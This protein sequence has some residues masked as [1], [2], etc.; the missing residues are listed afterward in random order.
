MRA[1][2]VVLFAVTGIFASA[3]AQTL[4]SVFAPTD[5]NVRI[6]FLSSSAGWTGMLRLELPESMDLLTNRATR[7]ASVGAG[8]FEAGTELVFSYDILRGGDYTW[9]S[10]APDMAEH[11]RFSSIEGEGGISGVLIEIEDLPRHRSDM[12][13]ND[14]RFVAWFAPASSVPAPGAAALLGLSG[15]VFSRR[16][17]PV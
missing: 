12:D 11:F 8:F 5:S 14:A 9:F 17:R 16:G 13:F 2:D 6:E 3:S 15:L 10:D 4:P 1:R 7:G